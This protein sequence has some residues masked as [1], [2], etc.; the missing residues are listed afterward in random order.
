M[1]KREFIKKS[2]MTAGGMMLTDKSLFANKNAE[3]FPELAKH[4]I[5]K[6]ELVTVNYQWPRFVGKNGA[7]DVHGQYNKENVLKIYTDQGAMGWGLTDNRVSSALSFIQGKKVSDLITPEK[8]LTDGLNVLYFDLPLFDLLGVIMDKPVYKILDGSG[9]KETPIY[10]GMIYFDEI[11]NKNNKGGIETIMENCAWD[12]DYG[13]RQFKIKI[14]RGKNWYPAKAGMEMDIKIVKKIY[15]EYKDKSIDILV[16]SNNSYSLED[17]ITFLKGIGDIPLYWVEEPFM[18]NME[19]GRKL[20]KWMNENGFGKTLYADGE[21][22]SAEAKEDIALDMVDARLVNTYLNDI[23]VY[24]LTNWMKVMPRLKKVNAGGSPH[25]WGTMLKTHYTAHL[26]AG[27]GS[28]PTI[29]GVTCLSDD[30]DYGNYPIKDG[31]IK[32]SDKPGFGMKLLK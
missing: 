5:Q 24:G 12:Y 4:K 8:G 30:I 23:H 21:W 29:E 18:E 17:T 16:D 3:K 27:L 20:R 28:I 32:V 31:K 13:Y 19:T 10:S 22:I 15:E 14:G 9:T 1:N 11:P 26:A 7:R 6:A 2:L 25:A